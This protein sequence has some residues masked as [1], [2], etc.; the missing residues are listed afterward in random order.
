MLPIA[1][2]LSGRDV[3]VI[4]AG[5]I[6]IRKAEQLLD[7]GAVVTVVA[8]EVLTEVPDGIELVERTVR[9]EDLDGRFL[10]VCATGVDAVDAEVRSWATAKGI[11]LNVADVPERCDFFFMAQ[12]RQGPVVVA[13]STEGN[14][15]ALASWVRDSIRSSLPS[16]LGEV[17]AVLAAERAEIQAQDGSTEGR[18]WA[19]RIEALIDQ[20]VDEPP[21]ST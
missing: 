4:G 5:K 18:D 15:P 17:A 12:H 2:D 16:N 10:V 8:P 11:L 21:R 6:G 13:V 14:A 3:L 20:G 9:E 7:E 19:A 1:L